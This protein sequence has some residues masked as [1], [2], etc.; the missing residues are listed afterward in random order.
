MTCWVRTRDSDGIAIKDSNE[1]TKER[2]NE[3]RTGCDRCS[4]DML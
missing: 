4:R 3:M 2:R 1:V